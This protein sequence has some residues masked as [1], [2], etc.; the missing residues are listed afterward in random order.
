ML[1][2]DAQAY[3]RRNYIDLASVRNETENMVIQNIVPASQPASI[4]LY[5][6][7]W[8]WWSD[9]SQPNFRNWVDGHPLANTGN[10]AASVINATYLGQWVENNCSIQLNFVCHNSELSS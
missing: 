4:G 8:I 9:G 3:C 10:C 2:Y 1:W 6:F 5:R 7:T